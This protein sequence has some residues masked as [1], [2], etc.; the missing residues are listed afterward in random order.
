MELLLA[1]VDPET[2]PVPAGWTAVGFVLS[3]PV[4]TVLAYA[5]DRQPHAVVPGEPPKAL[6]PT[7]VNAALVDAVDRAGLAV[8]PG[9]WLHALPLAFG[10]NR[11]TW[12]KDRIAKKGLHPTALRTLACLADAEDAEARGWLA[13]AL[14]R[15]ADEAGTSPHVD[16]RLHEAR[17]AADRV[18]RLLFTVRQGRTFENRGEGLD[19]GEVR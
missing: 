17:D 12:Q 2:D 15:Y 13:T 14:G 1:N 19:G 7:E 16:D 8:W 5:P 11:R 9:G 18:L 4:R 3:A 6:G 10:A